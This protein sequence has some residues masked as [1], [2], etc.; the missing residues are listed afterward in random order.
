MQIL[1]VVDRA[2]LYLQDGHEVYMQ[3]MSSNHIL[4]LAFCR[5]CIYIEI[6]NNT[7]TIKNPKVWVSISARISLIRFSVRVVESFAVSNI[8]FSLV[9]INGLDSSSKCTNKRTFSLFHIHHL[10]RSSHI[11]KIKTLKPARRDCWK[12]LYV[13]RDTRF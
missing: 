1:C 8:N 7:L 9:L 5:M 3:A 4:C 10:S 6:T 12:N 11:T 2:L 13:T